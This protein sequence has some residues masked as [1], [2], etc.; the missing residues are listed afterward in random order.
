MQIINDARQMSSVGIFFLLQSM[1][2]A[3][4][5]LGAFSNNCTDGL[6]HLID[7]ALH[8]ASTAI[9]ITMCQQC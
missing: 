4:D 2:E 8:L 3:S 7:S 9:N 6:W 1:I 5:E